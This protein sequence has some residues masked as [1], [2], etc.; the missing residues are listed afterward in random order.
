MVDTEVKVTSSGG[1]RFHPDA[2]FNYILKCTVA[3][4]AQNV[5]LQII[6]NTQGTLTIL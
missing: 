5:L 6:N 4:G 2:K 1:Q 3:C